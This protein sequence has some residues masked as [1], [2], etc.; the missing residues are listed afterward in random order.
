MSSGVGGGRKREVPQ[1]I[2]DVAAAPQGVSEAEAIAVLERSLRSGKVTRAVKIGIGDDA[3]VLARPGADM[4]WTVDTSIE[5]THFDLNWLTIEDV[6][7]RSFHAAVSDIAGMGAK[8][9]AALSSLA[10]PLG[11]SSQ[12]LTDFGRGQA[13]AAEACACP[14][15]GGNV[16]RSTT[17]H[18]TTTVLGTVRQ[19]LVRVGAMAGDEL[20]LVGSVGMAAAGL[21]LLQRGFASEAHP[22][23]SI[24]D[25]IQAWRRPSAR[26]AD[27]RR[28]RGRAHAA[29][30][31]SDGLCADLP[32]LAAAS[33]VRIVIE[34]EALTRC[35][36][37]SLLQVAPQLGVEPV[38]LAL[39]GGEDY[40]LIALGPAERRP[41]GAVSVGYVTRGRGAV[42]RRGTRIVG[43][44]TGGFDHFT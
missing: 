35:L 3:A 33:G 29:M 15:I 34:Q 9:L 14:V 8:P 31:V 20:W 2:R 42:L 44:L 1:R 26:L 18:I 17:W 38:A 13:S 27:G 24:L 22:S 16:A 5:G 10:F 36:K 23:K 7:W 11:T 25:C 40:A 28:L 39:Q 4:V 21:R 19:P 6:G 43:P 30:D 41:R 12:T 32:K 37:R